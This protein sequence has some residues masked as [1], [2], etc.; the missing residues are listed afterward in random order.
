MVTSKLLS[1]IRPIQFLVVWLLL[2]AVGA[3]AA[4]DPQ[5]EQKPYRFA[6]GETITINY[7]G[8]DHNGLKQIIPNDG[9]ISVPTGGTVNIL[10]KTIPEAQVLVRE[11]MEKESGLRKVAVSVQLEGIPSKKAFFSGEVK[12]TQALELPS[13][14][15]L[16]LLQALTIIGGATEFA[17]LS[18]VNIVRTAIDGTRKSLEI[19]ASKLGQSGNTDLGPAIEP[20]DVIIVPRG[21]VF[22]LAGEF[23]RQ[24]P[25]S[26]K[27]LLLNRGE[28]ARLSR[29]LFMAGGLKTTANRRTLRVI[30]TL[31]NG[32]KDVIPIDFDSATGSS[33]DKQAADAKGLDG[34][35]VEEGKLLPN[36]KGAVENKDETAPL[37]EEDPPAA[38]TKI[39]KNDERSR[40]PRPVKDGKTPKGVKDVAAPADA[41]APNNARPKESDISLQDG[42]VITVAG[43]GGVIILGKIKSPGLYAL[44]GPTLKLSRLIAMAGGFSEFAKGSSVTVIRVGPPKKVVSVDVNAVVKDGRLE[45][46][47]ELEDGDYVF[48]GERVL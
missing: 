38:D 10:G 11:L 9:T 3:R 25:I 35:S 32:E 16:N 14:K 17:D 13:G 46:D 15:S 45:K 34:D 8:G 40:E 47:V 4:E 20:D 28:P 39:P 48:V 18:R 33:D 24:G 29:V 26:R 7:A 2:C 21:D 43:S 5:P 44:P 27:E 22:I 19:D 6:G 42:D 31:K 41:K 30:R 1:M 12:S 36:P 23:A 37:F